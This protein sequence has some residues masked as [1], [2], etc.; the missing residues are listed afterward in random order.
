MLKTL[1]SSIQHEHLMSQ[2]SNVFDVKI[3]HTKEDGQTEKE[4]K[5]F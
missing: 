1:K 5:I 3:G 4:N 2:T